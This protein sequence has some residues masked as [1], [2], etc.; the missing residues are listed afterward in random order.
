MF[1][2]IKILLFS[3]PKESKEAV[4]V[5]DGKKNEQMQELWANTGVYLPISTFL[6][7]H[8][9]ADKDANKLFHALFAAL[10]KKE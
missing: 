4:H 7:I 10:I 5:T 3:V 6:T 2:T 1:S 8:Q 9:K